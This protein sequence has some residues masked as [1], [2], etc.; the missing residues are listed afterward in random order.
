MHCYVALVCTP[1]QARAGAPYSP[2]GFLSILKADLE[3]NLILKQNEMLTR[4]GRAHHTALQD[5]QQH[6]R[7]VHPFIGIPPDPHAPH[8]HAVREDIHLQ[9]TE[10]TRESRLGGCP[11]IQGHSLTITHSACKHS[12]FSRSHSCM[13]TYLHP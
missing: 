10:C 1:C 6:S 9:N 5:S 7:H 12:S 11:A 4:E 13:N 8:D 2:A 3:S